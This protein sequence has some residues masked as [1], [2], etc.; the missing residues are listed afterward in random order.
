MSELRLH[1]LRAPRVGPTDGVLREGALEPGGGPL[2]CAIVAVSGPEPLID[3]LASGLPDGPARPEALAARARAGTGRVLWGEPR[4][5]ASPSGRLLLSRLRGES[6]VA[7]VRADPRLLA[8]MHI[9]SWYSAPA[10]Q[11][12]ARRV[13]APLLARL[14]RSP[15]G[16]ER[17]A[18]LGDLHFW[19][20][21]RK[22]AT[23]AEWQ[24]ITGSSYVALYYHR[25]AGDRKPGQERLDVAP[26]QYARQLALLR[27]LRFRPVSTAEQLAFHLGGAV[28][29]PRSYVVTVDDGFYDV[30]EPLARHADH[31]PQLFVPTDEVGGRAWWA[32]GEAIVN[33]DQLQALHAGG[34]TVGSHSATHIALPEL[35]AE[36]LERSLVES[37]R[38][39]AERLGAAG[40][41]LAYP[42][43]RHDGA[44]RAAAR[45][46]GYALAYSTDPGRN[47]AGTPQFALRR[48]GIKDWDN[49]WSLVFKVLTGRPIPH[50]WDV[51]LQWR[52]RAGSPPSWA[53][54][55]RGR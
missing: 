1:P 31:R 38:E 25:L 53:R 14:A 26:G 36:A 20:G 8:D 45:A 4:T 42:H 29:P 33:W 46:A 17:S 39:L 30:V 21:V 35:P 10:W 5:V 49:S 9:G 15:R 7:M 55:G 2:P 50:R 16:S 51:R 41:V 47:G 11:R 22:A 27:R 13:A 44:V 6:S 32:G 34:V 43:G 24:R 12:L 18:V 37:R 28:L 54:A 3:H 40:E 48:V 52:W 23:P 19:A